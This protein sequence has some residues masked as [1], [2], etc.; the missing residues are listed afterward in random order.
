MA[1]ASALSHRRLPLGCYSLGYQFVWLGGGLRA[2]PPL[3]L[4]RDSPSF[5]QIVPSILCRRGA[6]VSAHSVYVTLRNLV[7]FVDTQYTH[8]VLCTAATAQQH[9][10]QQSQQSCSRVASLT[11]RRSVQVQSEF[12]RCQA[13][14]G[15]RAVA[16]WLRLAGPAWRACL[17]W[18]LAPASAWGPCCCG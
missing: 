17:L 8:I 16:G 5:S 11:F 18:L 12:P 1:G 15:W 2:A 9:G 6:H 13:V 14:A 4:W 10:V 7:M 3:I